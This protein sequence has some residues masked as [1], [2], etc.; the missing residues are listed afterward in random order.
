MSLRVDSAFWECLIAFLAQSK[1]N[2]HSA[3]IKSSGY[4]RQ[5][6]Q[7]HSRR[8]SQIGIMFLYDESTQNDIPSI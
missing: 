5:G 4:F 1:G 6:F 7:I 8:L 3:L 2:Y